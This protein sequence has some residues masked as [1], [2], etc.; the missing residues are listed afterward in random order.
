MLCPFLMTR[1]VHVLLRYSLTMFIDK[2][3]FMTNLH[4]QTLEIVLY[5]ATKYYNVYHSS[6][7]YSSMWRFRL[8]FVLYLIKL[9]S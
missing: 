1:L 2:L 8:C 3:V 9:Q 4:K 7:T 5:E 6:H